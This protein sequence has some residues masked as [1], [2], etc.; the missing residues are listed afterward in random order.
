MTDKFNPATFAGDMQR[1]TRQQKKF[2]EFEA[3]L[4]DPKSA[5]F[6]TKKMPPMVPPNFS[7]GGLVKMIGD[8]NPLGKHV[9][10][11]DTVWLLDNTAFRSSRIRSWEAEFVAAVFE[12]DPGCKVADI[13]SGIA[14]SV[15]LADDAK[16][17]ET[18]EERILPFLW[19]IRM[20]RIVKVAMRGKELK[21]T[22]T[23][24]NGISTQVLK[25]PKAE[26]GSLVK[27]SAK[28]PRGANGILEAQTFY[29][30]PEGWGIISDVDDT[31]K[32]TMTSDPVGILE[33]TFC[34][35]P[36]PVPGMPELYRDVQSLLPEDTP[37]FYLSA[38]PY[39]LYPFIRDF[40]DRY[41]PPGTLIL[42]D[43]SWKTVAG[44]LSALTMGTEEYKA[45]RMKKVN[46]WF[47]NRKMIVIGDSTQSDPEA[48]GE[49]YRTVPG[50]IKLILIRKVEDVA[51]VGIEDKNLPDRFEKA[52]EGVPRQAWHVFSDPAECA[53]IIRD[54]IFR[55]G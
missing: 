4:P 38:S 27:A 54:T 32:I 12:R 13:V 53:Q 11:D 21:M 48:Y 3:G 1:R 41:Y 44:L 10:R 14:H 6:R 24:V 8:M 45:D 20:V 25:I 23:N 2:D 49:I 34:N 17:R 51:A 26:P 55:D 7:L 52:F 47:P 43:F 35:E 33:E 19:D 15:G 29:A 22:P 46:G 5:T 42:R 18:I 37:W 31:I 40:R 9:T 28:V 36:R 39:N 50:W 16:E 30:G